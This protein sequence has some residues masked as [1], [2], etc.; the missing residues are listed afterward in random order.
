MAMLQLDPREPERVV[1]VPTGATNLEKVIDPQ[2]GKIA[3]VRYTVDGIRFWDNGISGPI[4]S[5]QQLLEEIFAARRP[6][7]PLTDPIDYL[8]N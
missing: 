2:T 8:Y 4:R 5:T 1:T 6:T 7:T 3:F